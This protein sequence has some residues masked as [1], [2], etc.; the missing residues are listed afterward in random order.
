MYTIYIRNYME[1]GV[2]QTKE[3]VMYTIPDITAN[4]EFFVD[5]P[6]AKG[7][8]G[9]S[10]SFDFSLQPSSPWYRKLKY[11]LTVFRIKYDKKTI[12]FGRLLDYS[13]DDFGVRSYHCEGGL[14]FL[15]DSFQSPSKEDKRKSV[16]V[17]T[18]MQTMINQHNDQ[19][20]KDPWKWITLG[21]VP[22][23]YQ[24]SNPGQQIKNVP[25]AKYGTDTWQ[26]TMSCFEELVSDNGGYLRTRYENQNGE[27]KL[28][29]DWF[30]DY[31]REWDNTMTPIEVSKNLIEKNSKINVEKLF[32]V[33]IP[34]GSKKGDDF[35][36]N[37][38]CWPRSGHANVPYIE[39]PELLTEGVYTEEELTNPY[40]S[41]SVFR[42]A[43]QD[44]GHVCKVQKFENATTPIQLFDFAK[45]W[46]KNNYRASI[47]NIEAKALDLHLIGEAANQYS[48]GDQIKL[49]YRD[50]ETDLIKSR[51]LC[52]MAIQYDLMNPE[53]NTYSLGIPDNPY[54]KKYG[55]KQ[56]SG[57]G[58]GGGTNPPPEDQT[59]NTVDEARDKIIKSIQGWYIEQG[60]LKGID[61]DDPNHDPL[62][63]LQ[64]PLGE[65]LAALLP[66]RPWNTNL[67]MTISDVD[68]INNEQTAK[69]ALKNM[70]SDSLLTAYMKTSRL[71]VNTF[72][73][74]GK[75][76][77][78]LKVL[79]K[80]GNEVEVLGIN[81]GP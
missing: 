10:E 67:K 38:L 75:K 65:K 15:L 66:G 37:Y 22:G 78:T 53:N 13:E 61:M 36:I 3:T 23:Q 32:T 47:I 76:V 70:R 72:N 41:G 79:D 20:G 40:Y 45:D 4:N 35:H 1:N 63:E 81:E 74:A 73:L 54:N 9:K 68:P 8:M 2:L 59:V 55:T 11:H 5:S 50:P 26:E 52:I 46:I 49:I 29:L 39:V 57:G 7:E 12:F 34:Y 42:T 19:V 43:I 16:S 60:L 44:Y 58:G 14:S 77:R 56:K 80:D 62:G 24:N 33:L 51:M 18:W 31:F 17:L 25:N 6:R 64:Y 71:D 28:Y 30:I 27:E 69:D 21:E 48:I